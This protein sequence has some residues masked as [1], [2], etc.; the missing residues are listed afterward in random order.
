MKYIIL[1][2]T[3]LLSFNISAQTDIQIVKVKHDDG[4]V[5]V[6]AVNNSD[7][8]YSIS[9]NIALQGMKLDYPIKPSINIL[10]GEEKEI[11]LLKPTG[12]QTKYK[13]NFQATALEGDQRMTSDEVVP[14]ITI[15]TK[16]GQEKS[17][18]LRLYLKKH[19]IAYYEINATYDEKSKEIYENMLR[20]RNISKSDAK[21]PVVII[22]GEVY[23]H[24]KDMKSFIK[25]HFGK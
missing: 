24:I 11:A 2:A 16:N 13:I 19:E 15:Y 1:F 21:L 17:T 8:A 23:H 18:E 3:V 5:T 22:R 7:I 14:D 25:E 10:S 12:S 6:Y 4:S 20:R 9:V